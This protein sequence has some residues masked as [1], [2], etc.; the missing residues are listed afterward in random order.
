MPSGGWLEK[1]K[2]PTELISNGQRKNSIK[3]ISFLLMFMNTNMC[4]F[5]PIIEE[6]DS[7]YRYM[8]LAHET[9]RKG[10]T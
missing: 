8:H 3:I 7:L 1:V 6:S 10:D 2:K 9:Y 4:G 5:G